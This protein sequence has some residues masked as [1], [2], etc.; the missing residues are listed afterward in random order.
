MPNQGLTNSGLEALSKK[1]SWHVGFGF[2][3]LGFGSSFCAMRVAGFSD[4][5][6]QP[7]GAPVG[8]H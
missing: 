1:A 7:Y 8:L 3:V 4:C 2:R 5:R 6:I